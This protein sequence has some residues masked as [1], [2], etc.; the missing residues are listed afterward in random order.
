MSEGLVRCLKFLAFILIIFHAEGKLK[1]NSVKSGFLTNL[2]VF[3]SNL[4][5]NFT[6]FSNQFQCHFVSSQHKFETWF[7]QSCT[8]YSS[9]E[10]RLFLIACQ[11]KYINLYLDAP[12]MI[13]MLFLFYWVVECR[14][15]FSMCGSNVYR[16]LTR[17]VNNLCASPYIKCFVMTIMTFF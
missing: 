14:H 2:S 10:D 16:I 9:T 7:I 13:Y 4:S 17:I 1:L 5:L 3:C 15:K 6:L 12:V 11:V 8:F